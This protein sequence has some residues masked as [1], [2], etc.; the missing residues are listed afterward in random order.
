M[1]GSAIKRNL[2][3]NSAGSKKENTMAKSN[4]NPSAKPDSGSK[5]AKVGKE[6]KEVKISF[7]PKSGHVI[8]KDEKGFFIPG[9][10]KKMFF[11]KCPKEGDKSRG[12]WKFGAKK[13]LAEYDI[14]KAQCKFEKLTTRGSGLDKKTKKLV[15]LRAAVAE[16]EAELGL[17]AGEE[18][19]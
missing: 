15:K 4:S 5:P 10:P 11:A 7:D 18:I 2:L 1:S 8:T 14:F 13:S 12:A 9:I 16:L 3:G 19:K 6:K 17:E